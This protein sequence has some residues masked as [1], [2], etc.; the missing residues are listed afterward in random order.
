[1]LRVL[2]A[3]LRLAHPLIPF[4][5]EELWQSIKDL[6]GR[7]GES[8]MIQAYPAADPARLD[9]GAEAR[10]QLLKDMVSACRSLRG[11]MNISPAQKVPLVGSGDVGTL[12]AVGPYLAAL[13]KLSEVVAV[14]TLPDTE[15]PVQIVGVFRL[16]LK[17]EI[18]VAAERLRLGKELERIE[19]EIAKAEKKLATPS[20]VDRAPTAVVAQERLRLADFCALREKLA[21]QLQRLK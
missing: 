17:V 19:G 4:I 9:S 14:D 21:A 5:T 16:M 12:Q 11:E 2:E 13:A 7:Q 15:A 10:I 3:T 18:D 1:L 8:I 6:A 20:F